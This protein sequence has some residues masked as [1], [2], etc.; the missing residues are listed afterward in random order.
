MQ[1][2]LVSVLEGGYSLKFVGKIAAS[3]IAKMSE[4]PYNVNEKVPPISQHQKREGRKRS[5]EFLAY[6]LENLKVLL[7][8]GEFYSIT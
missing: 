7:E 2:K 1:G 8:V 4:T 3:I 6:R 5:K